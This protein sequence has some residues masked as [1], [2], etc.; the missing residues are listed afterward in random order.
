MVADW[1]HKNS[2][3]WTPESADVGSSTIEVQIRDGLHAK[4]GSYDANASISY[5][6]I[7][8]STGRYYVIRGGQVYYRDGEF[9]DGMTLLDNL[10]VKKYLWHKMEH[11]GL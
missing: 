6:V 7:P 4:E 8:A 10:Q 2:W 1:S 11:C 9:A 3:T 5:T